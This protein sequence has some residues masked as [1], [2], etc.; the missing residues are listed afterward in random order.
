MIANELVLDIV[1]ET[2]RC[3]HGQHGVDVQSGLVPPFMARRSGSCN[4]YEIV[5]SCGVVAIWAYGEQAANTVVAAMNLAAQ[6]G[7][8]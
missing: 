6:L 1:R 2:R 4:G 8:L 7:E 3:W 5:D